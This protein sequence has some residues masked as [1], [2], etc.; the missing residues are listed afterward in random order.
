MPFGIDIPVSDRNAIR[1]E[2]SLTPDDRVIVVSGRFDQNAGMRFA[3][4]AFD[5]VRLIHEGARLV[6]IGDGP[7][8]PRV[9]RFVRTLGCRESIRFVGLRED[10]ARLIAAADLAWVTHRE[11]GMTVAHEALAA[12]V[13]VVGFRTDD[14]ACLPVPSESF[15]PYGDPAALSVLSCDRLARPIPVDP[16]VFP[17]ATLA[18]TVADVYD[19]LVAR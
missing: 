4:W 19:S 13:S 5:L 15:V 9:E 18:A 1:R 10:A 8:R 3:L 2:M 12:G 14:T 16:L 17:V 11:G 6:L 7:E